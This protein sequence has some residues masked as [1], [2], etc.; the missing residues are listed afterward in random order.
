MDPFHYPCHGLSL[1]AVR[2][3]LVV[4]TLWVKYLWH[5]IP[6]AFQAL[7]SALAPHPPW[8]MYL[9]SVRIIPDDG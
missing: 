8:A 1:A 7:P 9:Y 4:F 5:T 2:R 6:D 3:R